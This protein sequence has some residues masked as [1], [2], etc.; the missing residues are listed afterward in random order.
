MVVE[1][2]DGWSRIAR[3]RR[4]DKVLEQVGVSPVEPIEDAD[5]DEDR[6]ERRAEMID[7]LDDVHRGLSRREGRPVA[8]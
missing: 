7:P 8:R 5:D 3:R 2:D 1:G 4:R 6:S